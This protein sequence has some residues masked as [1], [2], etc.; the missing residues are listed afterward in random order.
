M[1][2]W[3]TED[4]RQK[5]T[6]Q[7]DVEELRRAV[8]GLAATIGFERAAAEEIVLAALEL[9]TNLLRY[10]RG[11]EIHVRRVHGNGR[12]GIEMSSDDAGPGIE[13]VER[14]LEEGYSSGKGLGSGLPAVR[15]LTDE[16]E[17]SSSPEG[18]HVRVRKWLT[19]SR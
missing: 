2:A 12:D 15:R 6:S 14:A 3:L 13:D 8:R 9:S 10:A 11:G 7:S 4:L 18:T 1:A 16:F 19:D 5:V 17:I